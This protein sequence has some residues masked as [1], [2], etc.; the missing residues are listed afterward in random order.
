[1][2]WR[3]YAGRVMAE[4]VVGNCGKRELPEV[5]QAGDADT[6]EPERTGPVTERAVEQTA[7]ELADLGAVVDADAQ[8]RRAAADREVGVAQ[9]GRD[10]A[11]RAAGF[12]QVLRHRPSHPSQLVM[13]PAAIREV[14]FERVLDADRDARGR[15]LELAPVDAARALAQE[16]PDAPRQQ[17]AEIDV[18]E[19]S[20]RTN[21]RHARSAEPRL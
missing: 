9:L 8:R 1:P 17:P 4:R 11:R 16:R 7:R 15:Q 5:R 19:R 6:D 14:A 10:R 18:A 12:A 13:Q 3:R 20:E 2:S 21:R